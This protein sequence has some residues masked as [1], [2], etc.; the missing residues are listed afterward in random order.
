MKNRIKRIV[1]INYILQWSHTCQI[2]TF[3][4][5]N[6]SDNTYQFISPSHRSNTISMKNTKFYT[7]HDMHQDEDT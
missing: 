1:I 2:I 4:Y 5:V 3:K 7:K 6:S